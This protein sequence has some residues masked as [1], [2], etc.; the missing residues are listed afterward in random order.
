MT[1]LQT[2]KWYQSTN[3]WTAVLL[4]IGGLFVGFPEEAGVSMIG[5]IFALI[6]SVGIMRNFFKSSPKPD[7]KKIGEVNFWNYIAAI[8]TAIVPGVLP[9]ELFIRLQELAE[10]LL[11]GNWQGVIT[12]IFSIATILY[13]L[14]KDSD[15]NKGFTKA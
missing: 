7:F 15:P 1:N 13:Y 3:F 14:I 5:Q 12:A 4:A 2:K 10:S 11:N 8:A 6:G 9:D